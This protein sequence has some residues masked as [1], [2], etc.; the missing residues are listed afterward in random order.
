MLPKEAGRMQTRRK[1]MNFS[2]DGLVIKEQ[3]I[4]DGNKVITV[5][6]RDKGVIRAFV[7]GVD[8][9]R[10]SKATA[11]GL[12]TYS[13]FEVYSNSKGKYVIDDVH[14]KDVFMPLRNDMKKLAL[15]QY[16]CELSGQFAPRETNA[17]ET[18]RLIL[19]SLYMIAND[20]RSCEQIKC[21]FEL[22]LMAVSGYMP[23]LVGCMECGSFEDDEMRFLPESGQMICGKCLKN[24]EDKTHT[25]TSMFIGQTLTK[26]MRHCVYSEFG[27]LFS[28]RISDRAAAALGEV[29]EKYC[30]LHT[31]KPLR[32]LEFYKQVKDLPPEQR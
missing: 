13:Q 31:D 6:T 22:R 30:T 16:F 2:T 21:I 14:A 5:L 11:T 1:K 23:D 17:E 25:Q 8:N 27:K 15:A 7:N 20:K 19:N 10:S 18:L 26:A 3:M 32:T 29:T 4:K 9:I 24:D 28:F 12:V